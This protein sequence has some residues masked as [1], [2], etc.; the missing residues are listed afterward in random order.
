MIVFNGE[1]YQLPS[2]HNH[3]KI[4]HLGMICGVL[5]HFNK[6]HHNDF[7]QVFVHVEGHLTGRQPRRGRDGRWFYPALAGEMKEQDIYPPEAKYGRKIYCDATDSGP[8]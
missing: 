4:E 7:Y 6:S 1:N 3:C 8:V 5:L 2:N